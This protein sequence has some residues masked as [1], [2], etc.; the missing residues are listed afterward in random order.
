MAA[1]TDFPRPSVAVDV[2]VCTVVDGRLA[3]V[4]WRRAGRTA[5]R[6]WA[7]PGSFVQERERLRDAVDRTLRDKCGLVGLAPTQLRVMDDPSRDNRGWVLSVAHLDVV[8]FDSLTQRK[9]DGA[10]QV[11]PVRELLRRDRRRSVLE[12][13]DKQRRLPFDHEETVTFAVDA[14]RTRYA[15]RPDPAGLL[16]SWFTI[17]QLRRLHEAVAGVALQKD[18]FRRAMVPYLEELDGSEEGTVGRPARLFRRR[19]TPGVD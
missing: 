8:A 7:L 6:Q 10:V 12:L 14:L 16:G 1:L 2:A 17:L 3:V 9:E 15:E 19:R 5:H 11:V 4:V 18:T 13:P